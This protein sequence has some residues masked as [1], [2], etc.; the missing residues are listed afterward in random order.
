MADSDD[1]VSLRT[2]ARELYINTA[3]VFRILN[4]LKELGYVRQHPQDS[5]YQLTLKI[6]GI[7]SH[8]LEKVQ[9]RQIA[10]PFLQH[11]T[12]ITNE[13]THLAIL[14]GNEFVYIDKVDNTQAMR[15]R[16]MVG[17]RG[18]LY[19]TAVGKSLLAY[20]PEDE[21]S[22][23][24]DN[25]DFLPITKNTITDPKKFKE[26][27]IRVKQQ[28]YAIDDEENEFGIRCIGSPI[29]DHA[30]CL[31]GALSISG[32]TITMTRE[33]IPQLVQ[34]LLQTCQQISNELGFDGEKY[35]KCRE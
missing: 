1:W 24:L 13:T 34:E 27:L 3:S 22:Q 28:G 33:R 7:S 8:V 17:Q 4:A 5:K 16:S 9:L 12:S 29:Y 2:M 31:A 32:W 14:D 11:L 19:C 35:V 20:Y 18:R 21:L 26:H 25:L 15:M 10:R 23:I 30:G 6:A